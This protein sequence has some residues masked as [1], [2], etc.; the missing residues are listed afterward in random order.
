[1]VDYFYYFIAIA[2]AYLVG[3]IPFAYIAGKVVAGKDLRNVGSGNLGSSNVFRQVS[4]PAGWAVFFLDCAK[5][6]L[7]LLLLR[8]FGLPLMVQSLAA[9]AVMAG[10]NWSVFTG[11]EGGRGMTVALVG[12]G[13]LIPWETLV[14]LGVVTFGG[15]TGT[16]AMYFAFAL[17]LWPVLTLLRPEPAPLVLL[18]FG[19]MVLGFARRLQGSPGVSEIP[20]EYVPR[21]YTVLNRLLYDREYQPPWLEGDQ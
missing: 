10:H 19:I 17:V 20:L 6:G 5:I 14:V 3:S 21:K 7:T 9:L 4:R 12:A 1:M 16:I 13:I 18:A 8:L 11:F 15:A 2:A